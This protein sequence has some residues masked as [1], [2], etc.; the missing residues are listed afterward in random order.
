MYEKKP[1]LYRNA[2]TTHG[3]W[4][5]GGRTAVRSFLKSGYITYKPHTQR[6]V[7]VYIYDIRD[8]KRCLQPGQ[9]L[10]DGTAMLH[11]N[12]MGREERFTSP[13]DTRLKYD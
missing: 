7:H 10:T 8:G 5:C 6:L 11:S 13:I 1:F 3:D 4:E 9:E 2:F 12:R